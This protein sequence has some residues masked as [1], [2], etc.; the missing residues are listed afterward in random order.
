MSPHVLIVTGSMGSGKTTILGEASDLLT[1]ARVPHA[2]IDLDTL[3]IGFLEGGLTD[4]LFQNLAGVWR[5]YA[6]AGIGRLL[7]AA[8]VEDAGTLARIRGAI[9]GASIT[10]GR[11]VA[12]VETMQDRVRLREPGLLQS[13]FVARAAELNEILDRAHLEQFTITND[14][15][16]ATEVARELLEHAGW[17]L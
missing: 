6:G 15:R 13:V 8:A 7:L 14:G 4:V 1:A 10:I 11:L 9:P 3:G 12:S 5:G 16:P 17:P 2:G